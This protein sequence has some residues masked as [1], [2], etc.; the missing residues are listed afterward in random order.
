VLGRLDYPHALFH[1]LS[2][3][4]VYTPS[5]SLCC[6][7]QQRAITPSDHGVLVVKSLTKDLLLAV[8]QQ[9]LPGISDTICL[10]Q[11]MLRHPATAISLIQALRLGCIDTQPCQ[12]PGYC[13]MYSACTSSDRLL[14]NAQ[15]SP[16][17]PLLL[18]T[19]ACCCYLCKRSSRQTTL[20]CV[21]ALP[22]GTSVYFCYLTV[23]RKQRI[24]DFLLSIYTYCLL[25]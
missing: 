5:A 11:R 15:S 21:N 4:N 25:R 8:I 23:L 10:K 14:H 24:S 16:N 12:S 3:R 1:D 13:H 22:V 20:V 18:P 6:C 19:A 7:N 2:E 17:F 9:R